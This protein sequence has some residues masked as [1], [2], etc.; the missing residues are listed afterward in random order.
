M[1][2]VFTSVRIARGEY[3]KGK[4]TGGENNIVLDVFRCAGCCC[5]V[6]LSLQ[7]FIVVAALDLSHRPPPYTHPSAFFFYFALIHSLL[8]LYFNITQTKAIT[9][10]NNY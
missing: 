10:T 3:K 6:V 7:Q 2:T 1:E 4:S 5:K 8:S 9:C